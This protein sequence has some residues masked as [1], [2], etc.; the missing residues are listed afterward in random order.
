MVRSKFVTLICLLLA[1]SMLTGCGLFRP[2]LTDYHGVGHV[3]EMKLALKYDEW[4]LYYNVE[5]IVVEK[6]RVRL[7]LSDIEI[8]TDEDLSKLRIG[9][10]IFAGWERKEKVFSK[11]EIDSIEYYPDYYFFMDIFGNVRSYYTIDIPIQKYNNSE[12]VIDLYYPKEM[13]YNGL[14]KV[15]QQGIDIRRDPPLFIK[16]Y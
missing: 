6:D 14:A 5:L 12:C 9:L 16:L 7:R 2:K 4:E 15:Y 11:A 13:E 3:W 8:I 1:L 10:E